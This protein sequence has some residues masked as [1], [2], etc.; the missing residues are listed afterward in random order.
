MTKSLS[1]P[2]SDA[3]IGCPPS[4]AGPSPVAANDSPRDGSWT[5]PITGRPAST[6]AI[7]TQKNGMP[8]A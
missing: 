2:L 8:L 7:E 5:T 3:W 1:A 6:S 4:V